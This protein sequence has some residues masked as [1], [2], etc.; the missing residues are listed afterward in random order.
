M[1]GTIIIADKLSLDNTDLRV[2]L[3]LVPRGGFWDPLSDDTMTIMER[4]L[5]L[6][7]LEYD[8]IY[9]AEVESVD[10]PDLNQDIVFENINYHFFVMYTSNMVFSD[11]TYNY[12]FPWLDNTE[13]YV[14]A[15]FNNGDDTIVDTI[16]THNYGFGYGSYFSKTKYLIEILE[17]QEQD[18]RVEYVFIPND[19]EEF[20]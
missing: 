13:G 5:I 20:S 14:W 17:L 1:S 19:D 6:I 9:K 15:A 3:K 16:R 7:P 18:I 10:Y 4:S 11:P 2:E 12:M 8:Y